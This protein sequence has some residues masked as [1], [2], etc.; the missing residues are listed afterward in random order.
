MDGLLISMF[1]GGNCWIS[2]ARSVTSSSSPKGGNW[3]GWPSTSANC[4]LPLGC[5]RAPID[6]DLTAIRV[7]GRE[8]L[9]VGD[10]EGLEGR[11]RETGRHLKSDGAT[12]VLDYEDEMA[13][14]ILLGSPD[15]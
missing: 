15:Q 5:R 7:R 12:L 3:I 1:S 4:A 9:D 8:F 11:V 13:W 14:V 2:A 6:L 10:S